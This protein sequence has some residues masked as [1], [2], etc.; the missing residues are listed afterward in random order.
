ME[1]PQNPTRLVLTTLR[2]DNETSFASV[3]STLSLQPASVR[4][5]RE[6]HYV[7]AGNV[8]NPLL[9]S[10]KQKK[11]EILR[12]PEVSVKTV[13]N[14]IIILMIIAKKNADN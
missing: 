10:H 2:R 3:Y 5:Y 6:F 14:N 8:L 11:S 4:S 13:I 7:T 1:G 9:D 12:Y